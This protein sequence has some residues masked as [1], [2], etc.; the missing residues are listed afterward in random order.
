MG[1]MGV[2]TPK[3]FWPGAFEG[4]GGVEGENDR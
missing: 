3:N 4:L 2:R 1:R